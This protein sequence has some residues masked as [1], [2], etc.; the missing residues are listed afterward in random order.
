MDQVA[1]N[2]DSCDSN[3]ISCTTESAYTVYQIDN[4]GKDSSNLKQNTFKLN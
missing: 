3:S 1:C 4:S 2:I